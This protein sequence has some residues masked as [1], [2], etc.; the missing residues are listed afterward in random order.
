MSLQNSTRVPCTILLPI[1]NASSFLPRSLQ[2]LG[3]IAGPEDEILVINDGSTDLSQKILE[4]FQNN[5]KRINV[6]NREHQ[7]LVRSLN[8]GIENAKNEF[9]A[10]ADVDDY[11]AFNRI[12]VQVKFLKENPEI[13]AVF[14]DYEMVD[15][16]GSSLG[17]FP[18]AI[19]PALTAFSLVS[20]QRTAHPSV[21]YRKTA[22][23]DAGGYSEED[24]PAE[25]LALWLRLIETGKIASI[26]QQ[27]LKYT[28]HKNSITSGHRNSMLAKSLT[29]RKSFAQKGSGLLLLDQFQANLLVYKKSAD[30]N[31]RI[32]FALQDLITFNK[33]TEGKHEKKV[34]TLIFREVLRRHMRLL[35]PLLYVFFIKHKRK[36]VYFKKFSKSLEK[37]LRR[38][39]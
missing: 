27:F 2:N 12:D 37:N 34:R 9:I 17:K 8:F 29:L 13:H 22:I 11:Y 1:F 7:G 21:M 19:S 35:P 6:Y 16:N 23:L 20:S 39:A 10:R 14:C 26:P 33:L 28:V 18:S 15:L 3:E 32:L 38:D 24:F 5:D 31:L 30:K 36:K 25:D 4:M